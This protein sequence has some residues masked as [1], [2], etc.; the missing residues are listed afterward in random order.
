MANLQRITDAGLV[1]IAARCPQLTMLDVSRCQIGDATLAALGQWAPGL[2]SLDISWCVNVSDNGVMAVAHGCR[3]LRALQ[4][5]GC[6]KLTSDSIEMVITATSIEVYISDSPVIVCAWQV[7]AYC[8]ALAH[9]KM[10]GPGSSAFA[11]RALDCRCC[12]SHAGAAGCC[13]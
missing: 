9:L 11:V 4:Y 3:G 2:T 5:K 10:E 6:R 1:A 7:A 13:P 12:V 8:P